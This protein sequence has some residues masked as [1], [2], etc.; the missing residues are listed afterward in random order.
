MA[1]SN[2]ADS[3]NDSPEAHQLEYDSSPEDRWPDGALEL[4]TNRKE[5][6]EFM[7][8]KVKLYKEG[9]PTGTSISAFT[10]TNKKEEDDQAAQFTLTDKRTRAHN[11]VQKSIVAEKSRQDS[12]VRDKSSIKSPIAFKTNITLTLAHFIRSVDLPEFQN[13]SSTTLTVDSVF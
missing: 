3:E 8:W 7:K 1:R 10:F 2:S 4:P 9:H 5:I 12:I 6:N 13:F 11:L